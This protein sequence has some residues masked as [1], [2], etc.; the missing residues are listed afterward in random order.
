M[1]WRGA[2]KGESAIPDVTIPLRLRLAEI[3]HNT[4]TLLSPEHL[5]PVDRAIAELQQSGIVSRSLPV[6]ATTPAFKLP[7]QNGKPIRSAELL[8]SGPLIV[9]FYRGR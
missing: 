7:D 4:R 1:D 9:V 5:A 2:A 6:G 3:R 8:R